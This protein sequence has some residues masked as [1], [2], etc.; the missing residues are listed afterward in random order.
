MDIKKIQEKLESLQNPKKGKIQY[1]DRSITF[2]KPLV[3]KN[4]VR[5]VP[6]ILNKDNPFVELYFHYGIGP[7][8]MLSP[9]S[10]GEKDPI[11]EFANSLSKS[12]EPEDWALAKK[13]RPKMRTFAPVVS[14]SEEDKGVRWYEFGKSVYQELLALA[15]DEDVG[16]FSD[17]LEGRDIKVDVTEGNPYPET[18]IRPSMKSST[19]SDDSGTVENWLNNQPDLMSC[20]KKYSFDEIKE[21]LTKWLNPEESQDSDKKSQES[22][23]TTESNVAFTN[24]SVKSKKQSVKEVISDSEFDDIFNE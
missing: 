13:L 3:G 17:V 16:D 7:K 23:T 15:A 14:R 11:V 6:N 10:W 4:L 18:S 1:K 5:F 22:F 19:L 20:Y 12:K 24:D 8:V 9:I 21:F 2:W